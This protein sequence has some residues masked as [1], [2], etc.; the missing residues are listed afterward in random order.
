MQ[1]QGDPN[2]SHIWPYIWNNPIFMVKKAYIA[3]KETLPISLVFKWTW[4]SS[5]IGK[6]KFFFWLLLKD[7]LHTRNLLRRK[8]M[9]LDEYTYVMS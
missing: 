3:L 5:V 8:N 7:R 9:M 4:Q 2:T 6:H 1:V